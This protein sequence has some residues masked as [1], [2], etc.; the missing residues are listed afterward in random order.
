MLTVHSML[1]AIKQ[2]QLLSDRWIVGQRYDLCFFIGS[3]ISV[4]L[5]WGLYQAFQAFHI[6]LNGDSILITYLFFTALFDHPHIF[7]TFSRTHGDASEFRQHRWLHTWGLAS[8]ILLGFG[9]LALGRE[10]EL[11]VAAGVF[12]SYHIVRQH[13]GFLRAYKNLNQDRETIDDFLD[14][15]TFESGML[16]CLFNDYTDITGPVVIYKNIQSVFPELPA[17]L[18]E[19]TWATFLAF[20]ALFLGRQMVRLWVGQ[21]LNG[22]KLL[23]MLATL[24][25]HYFVFFATA[26]P[27]LVAESLETIYHDIQYQGWMMH[28]QNRRFP[29]QRWLGLKWLAV[30]LLYGA[31]AG[32]IEIMGLMHQGW[33]LWLMMPFTMVVIYHYAVDGVIW[34]FSRYPELRQVMF[35][36]SQVSKP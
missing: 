25:T 31:I 19:I 36:R 32:G 20:L 11:I 5:F 21:P 22:P 10:P 27:F 30:A 28:F 2:R 7:Q 14:F 23:L 35:A 8:F 12:G 26:T 15:G 24:S 4:V 29:T 17:E 16:A 33:W 13:Y 18:T 9:L 6:T 1:L 3:S 34:R